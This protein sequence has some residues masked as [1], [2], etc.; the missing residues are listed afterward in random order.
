MWQAVRTSQDSAGKPPSQRGEG[1]KRR[2]GPC[3]SARPDETG[4]LPKA[5]AQGGRAGLRAVAR[6][7]GGGATQGFV[8]G[9]WR[10]KGGVVA[11]GWRCQSV[12]GWSPLPW[13]ALRLW[14]AAPIRCVCLWRWAGRRRQNPEPSSSAPPSLSGTLPAPRLSPRLPFTPHFLSDHCRDPRCCRCERLALDLPAHE[15]ARGQR[16]CL[17]GW[18]S[19]RPA[20]RL[21]LS[22]SLLAAPCARECRGG[23]EKFPKS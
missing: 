5:A 10:E 23:P 15:L 19:D 17:L 11:A 1:D 12:S 16:W 2:A 22:S 8:P 3:P 14:K 7:R 20:S 13:A 4:Q 9:V 21:T 18:R 6:P